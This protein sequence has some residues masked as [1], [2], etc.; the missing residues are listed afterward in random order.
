MIFLD[1]SRFEAQNRYPSD[2][3]TVSLVIGPFCYPTTTTTTRTEA[4]AA[5][6]ESKAID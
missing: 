6:I 1:S 4:A 2:R 3:A 5:A